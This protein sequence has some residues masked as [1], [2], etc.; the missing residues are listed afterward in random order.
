[1]PARPLP[2]RTRVGSLLCVV[3]ALAPIVDLLFAA[4]VCAAAF[5]IVVFVFDIALPALCWQ[6]R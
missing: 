6:A 5:G 4:A 1:M 2:T 3:D